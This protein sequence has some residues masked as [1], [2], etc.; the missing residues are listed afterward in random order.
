MPIGMVEREDASNYRWTPVIA[1]A[2]CAVAASIV[3]GLFSTAL[4]WASLDAAT[5][6]ARTGGNADSA[7][8]FLSVLVG[9]FLAPITAGL[10]GG[11]VAAR[12]SGVAGERMSIFHGMLAWC[13]ALIV[14]ILFVG[15]PLTGRADV[16]THVAASD[17]ASLFGRYAALSGWT[18]LAALLGFVSAI[19]GAMMGRNMLHGVRM[20][21]RIRVEHA[22]QERRDTGYQ[23]PVDRNSSDLGQPYLRPN[24]PDEPLNRH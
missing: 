24:D 20:F 7:S 9:A 19:W 11:L 14:G 6:A 5:D 17:T 21:P 12:L 18:G 15:G 2:L 16:A 22:R 23:I 3:L 1:G 13:L 4:G 8:K 10:L